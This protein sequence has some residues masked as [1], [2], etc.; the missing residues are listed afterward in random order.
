MRSGETGRLVPA[1][2]P[3]PFARALA[4]MIDDPKTRQRQG[5]KA[6]EISRRDHDLDTAA[7]RLG[8]IVR[9]VTHGAR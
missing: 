6:L 9:E 3:E 4:E 7:K 2:R 8:D 1:G 5:A